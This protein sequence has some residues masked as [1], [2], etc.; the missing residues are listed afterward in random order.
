MMNVRQELDALIQSTLAFANDVRR[1]Q[2]NLD[3]PVALRAAQQA[4]ADTSKP[5]PPPVTI[6]PT[7]WPASA[8]DEIRQ[9][10]RDFKAHQEKMARE[11]EDYYLQ[12]KARMLASVP[13]SLSPLSDVHR[14]VVRR[15]GRRPV[16][17]IS[18]RLG[19]APGRLQCIQAIEQMLNARWRP[20]LFF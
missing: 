7:V 8:R 12:M 2:P 18:D 1:R 9:R 3:L 5:T 16:H 13:R 17:S 10:V 14:T 11:R 19:P 15:D 20:G 4:L 6:T